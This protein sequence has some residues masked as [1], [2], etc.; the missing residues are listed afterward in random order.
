M[1]PV[2]VVL[3][4]VSL[5]LISNLALTEKVA[6]CGS[7]ALFVHIHI[8]KSGGTSLSFMMRRCAAQR[9]R[10]FA[11]G[12]VNFLNMTASEQTNVLA[13]DAHMGYGIHEHPRFPAHR[14][15]CVVYM[16]IARPY[17][18]LLWSAMGHKAE[19]LRNANMSQHELGV[20]YHSEL[21]MNFTPWQSTHNKFTPWE[22]RGAISYQ[23]CCWSDW[24]HPRSHDSP[25]QG[26]LFLEGQNYE[27]SAK[28][29]Q[30]VE[31][32]ATCA[33]QR[34]CS[35]VDIVGTTQYLDA[36]IRRVS[37]TMNCSIPE[38]HANSHTLNMRKEHF[39]TLLE[40]LRQDGSFADAAVMK[41][42]MMLAGGDTS[43]CRQPRTTLRRLQAMAPA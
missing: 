32:A 43:A 33:V 24:Q 35:D 14:A 25:A 40:F 29:P 5:G 9:H 1:L 26:P 3:H 21:T 12:T 17:V 16:T 13:I 18:D 23:L 41:F 28:C 2:V 4:A 11:D 31:E 38:I 7:R 27:V 15:D 10:A 37:Q 34:L 8:P 20:S 6:R 19:H 39:D 36:M 22:F 42:A 30:T